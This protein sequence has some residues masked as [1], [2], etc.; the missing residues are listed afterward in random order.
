MRMYL[1]KRDI[2]RQL[3]N[4]IQYFPTLVELELVGT[5]GWQMK[6]NGLFFLYYKKGFKCATFD[7]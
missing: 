3:E 5:N 7:I 1:L 2:T 6:T 4:M